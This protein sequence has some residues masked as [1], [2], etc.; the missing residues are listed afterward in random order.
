VQKISSF[1]HLLPFL[2]GVLEGSRI[3]SGENLFSMRKYQEGESSRII[4]WKA[5]SKTGELM[6]K[7]F[8]EDEGSKF[9]LILDTWI[10][11][12]TNGFEEKFESAVSLAAGIAA[13]FLEEGA[14]MEFL[15]PDSYLNRGAGREQLYRILRVLAAIQYRIAAPQPD[16]ENWGRTS[17]RG[18]GV[19]TL[20]YIFSEKVF[21]IIISSKPEGNFPSAIRRSSHI[22]YFDEL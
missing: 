19:K 2:P 12:P 11:R 4:D 9:C 5:T 14:G 3:G 21:K 10:H 13:H 6:A 8:A 18:I 7:E 20:D 16:D 1:F 17:F 22:V 15:T